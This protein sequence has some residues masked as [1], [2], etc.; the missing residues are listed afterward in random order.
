MPSA[1]IVV[2]PG[3]AVS[4]ETSSEHFPMYLKDSGYNTNP[5]FDD[6]VFETLKTKIVGSGIDIASFA[7]TFNTEGV[8]Q[9]GD[10]A[11]PANA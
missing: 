2:A 1:I 6:G 5:N 9:F 8:Y 4:F 7:Y 11:D 10:Y 3:D